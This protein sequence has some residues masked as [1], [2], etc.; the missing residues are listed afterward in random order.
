MK[1]VSLLII[2]VL[3]L[4]ATFA[5]CEEQADK[6]SYNLSKEADNFNIIRQATCINA[7]TGDVVFQMTGRISVESVSPDKIEVI[8]EHAK[9][10]Y[11]K[12]F[13]FKGDNGIMVVEQIG[14][15]EVDNY[16][17]TLNFNPKMWIPVNVKTI[18]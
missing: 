16:K 7:I 9:G 2:F 12:H 13:L 4:V 8:V 18:D 3:L 15:A 5:G 17:Y 1:K 14:Y 6:V 11:A 10:E